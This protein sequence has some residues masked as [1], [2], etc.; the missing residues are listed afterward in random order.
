MRCNGCAN[1]FRDLFFITIP[2]V[3]LHFPFRWTAARISISRHSNSTLFF[4]SRLLPIFCFSLS[5]FHKKINRGRFVSTNLAQASSFVSLVTS[6]LFSFF[7]FPIPFRRAS[8]RQRS[9][10]LNR[11]GYIYICTY[12]I[13]RVRFRPMSMYALECIESRER[14]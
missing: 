6:F 13:N 8:Q 10:I 7:F 3:S 4:S 11:G 2:A 1:F 9:L 14:I 5:F 12:E